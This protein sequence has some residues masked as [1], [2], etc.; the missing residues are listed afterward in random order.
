MKASCVDRIIRG[1]IVWLSGVGFF[2]LLL[3]LLLL[4]FWLDFYL[5]V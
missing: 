1:F 3:L 5:F 2:S 4:L